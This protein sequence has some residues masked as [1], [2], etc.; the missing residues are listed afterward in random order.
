MACRIAIAFFL[1]FASCNKEEELRR[2]TFNVREFS[3]NTPTCTITYTSDA[4]GGNTIT[5]TSSDSWS[6][7]SLQLKPGSAAVLT[8]DCNEAAFD[9]K[10]Y[11]YVDGNL[12]E[13]KTYNGGSS[14]ETIS[15]S[16]P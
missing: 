15:I 13:T 14:P 5:S 1:L 2:V 7:P 16:V 3:A 11:V 4:T 9:Y 10:L 6:S 12:L 8:V